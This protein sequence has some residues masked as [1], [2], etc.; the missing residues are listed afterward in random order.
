MHGSYHDN[1]VNIMVCV[2]QYLLSW[3]RNAKRWGVVSSTD[4]RDQERDLPASIAAGP[5][6]HLGTWGLAHYF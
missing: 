5:T 6:G 1:L 2:R 4:G 3:S